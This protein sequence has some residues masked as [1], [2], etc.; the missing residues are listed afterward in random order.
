VLSVTSNFGIKFSLEYFTTS[1]DQ[2]KAIYTF[3]ARSTTVIV[4]IMLLLSYLH[5]LWWC[6]CKQMPLFGT[7][8]QN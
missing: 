2:D 4:I 7:A 8:V 3:L 5:W 6:C 1:S